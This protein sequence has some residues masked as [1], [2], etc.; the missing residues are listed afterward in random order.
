MHRTDNFSQQSSIIWPV[1]AVQTPPQKILLPVLMKTHFFTAAINHHLWQ[2][3]WT[4]DEFSMIYI[5]ITI[6][7][8]RVYSKFNNF[9]N[10]VFHSQKNKIRDKC[11]SFFKYQKTKLKISRVHIFKNS[12]LKNETKLIKQ[13]TFAFRCWKKQPFGYNFKNFVFCS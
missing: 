4:G 13:L 12:F 3:Q 9:S 1:L 11:V 2:P 5:F 10:C 8:N 7:V 6:F